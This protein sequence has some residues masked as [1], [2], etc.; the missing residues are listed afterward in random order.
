MREIE[1]GPILLRVE[2][3]A[4]LTALS[5]TTVFA[6]IARKELPSV[7]IGRSRRVVAEDLRRWISAHSAECN[8]PMLLSRSGET[9]SSTGRRG[10]PR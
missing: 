10:P 5:R 2:E 4:R 6:L 8:D 9:G 7:V 1:A 3:V